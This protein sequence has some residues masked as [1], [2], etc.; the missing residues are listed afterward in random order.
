MYITAEKVRC[1]AV[2]VRCLA[3]NVPGRGGSNAVV[4]ALR[5]VVALGYVALASYETLDAYAW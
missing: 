2:K 5:E 3:V 1:L 4:A